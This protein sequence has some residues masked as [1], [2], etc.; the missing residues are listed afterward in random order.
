MY[1]GAWGEK[2]E[3]EFERGSRKVGVGGL[4]GHRGG[5]LGGD[6]G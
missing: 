4:R 1:R 5:L 3:V 2:V 6:V